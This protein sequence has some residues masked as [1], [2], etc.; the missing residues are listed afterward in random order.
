M[1]ASID[2]RL[3]L[4]SLYSSSEMERKSAI[5]SF[6]PII[7]DTNDVPS[8]FMSTSSHRRYYQQAMICECICGYFAGDSLE[9]FFL[10]PGIFL[11]I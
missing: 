2:S 3:L 11:E 5:H 6:F 1:Q 10:N 4:Y 9:L 8:K 7:D